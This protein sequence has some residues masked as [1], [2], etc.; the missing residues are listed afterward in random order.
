MNCDSS[1]VCLPDTT[2]ATSCPKPFSLASDVAD[3]YG[4]VL[5]ASPRESQAG[6]PT[7]V[8]H[9]IPSFPGRI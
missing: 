9:G 7:V 6:G 2:L 5:D 8:F 3:I 1:G 4:V